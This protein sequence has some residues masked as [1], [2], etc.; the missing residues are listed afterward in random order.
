MAEPTR[1]EANACNWLK[2]SKQNFAQTRQL[3]I[4]LALSD[5]AMGFVRSIDQAN[6]GHANL[7]GEQA[8]RCV[9][10]S[11]VWFA[12]TFDH[13]SCPTLCL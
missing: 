1:P 7:H 6:V 13:A 8:N 10:Q 3:E 4:H 12:Q 5:L 9:V 11:S 2:N